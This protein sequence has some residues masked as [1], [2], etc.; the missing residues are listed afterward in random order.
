MIFKATSQITRKCFSTYPKKMY[1]VWKQDPSQVH[2]TWNEY[3]KNNNTN[4]T[5]SKSEETVNV[6]R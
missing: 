2:P 3:F 1:D 5:S 4:I 6:D